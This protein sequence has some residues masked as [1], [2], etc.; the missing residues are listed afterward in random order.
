MNVKMA[1]IKKN[2]YIISNHQN[3]VPDAKSILPC[4]SHPKMLYYM[5]PSRCGN[6][7]WLSPNQKLAL[8]QQICH[9]KLWFEWQ[10]LRFLRQPALCRGHL[11]Q[12]SLRA[13]TF[14]YKENGI[15]DKQL[16]CFQFVNRMSVKQA[17]RRKLRDNEDK[18]GWLTVGDSRLPPSPPPHWGLHIQTSVMMM[19]EIKGN[20]G[21][22]TQTFSKSLKWASGVFPGTDF[23]LNSD[24]ILVLLQ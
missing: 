18:E 7:S 16:E 3:P 22:I 24:N 13:R 17:L 15:G 5:Q 2:Q 10:P 4:Y 1:L 8:Q 9:N 11:F 6:Q 12:K 14:V 23:I 21:N 20:Q 19:E